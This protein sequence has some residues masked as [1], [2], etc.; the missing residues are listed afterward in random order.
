M[1]NVW[2]SC[3]GQCK[4]ERDLSEVETSVQCYLRHLLKWW[5][6]SATVGQSQPSPKPVPSLLLQHSSQCQ[7]QQRWCTQYQHQYQ[8]CVLNTNNKTLYLIPCQ[9][10]SVLFI[11]VFRLALLHY[12]VLPFNVLCLPWIFSAFISCG[13][14]GDGVMQFWAF[15]NSFKLALHC[16]YWVLN[17]QS[18]CEPVWW[19]LYVVWEPLWV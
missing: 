6:V 13:S 18:G 1:K 5:V 11:Y 8:Y 2:K 19:L 15:D 10:D 4:E 17:R 7:Y 9:R 14:M 12:V 3:D 16:M